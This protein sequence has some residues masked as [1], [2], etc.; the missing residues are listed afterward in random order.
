MKDGFK[1]KTK[2]V[3]KQIALIISF[4]TLFKE[5]TSLK[6]IPSNNLVMKNVHT[7]KAKTMT[8]A[9]HENLYFTV[10]VFISCINT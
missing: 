2:I 8:N 3:A 7:K 5:N 4:R 9:V 1:T 10:A 6:E